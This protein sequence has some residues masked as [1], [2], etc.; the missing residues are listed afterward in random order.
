[1]WRY[2]ELLSFESLATIRK[3][4]KEVDEGKNRGHQVAFA[5]EIVARFHHRAAAEKA[6][7]DFEAR[8]KQGQVP[9]DIPSAGFRLAANPYFFTKFSNRPV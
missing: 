4:K 5:Q 3:W 1:M 6:L 2:I 9:K 7:L 8:F